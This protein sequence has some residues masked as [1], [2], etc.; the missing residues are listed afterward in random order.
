MLNYILINLTVNYLVIKSEN[1]LN[2][3]KKKFDYVLGTLT[4]KKYENGFYSF[5]LCVCVV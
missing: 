2:H 4:S 3:V 1:F 5:E